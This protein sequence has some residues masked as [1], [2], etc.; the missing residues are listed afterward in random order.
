MTH[1]AKKDMFWSQNRTFSAEKMFK[2]NLLGAKVD[3]F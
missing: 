1:F 2:E 3:Y